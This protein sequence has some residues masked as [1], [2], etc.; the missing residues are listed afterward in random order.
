M[1]SSG[2]ESKAA[3]FPRHE[4][5]AIEKAVMESARGRWFLQEFARR[6]RSADT[7]TLLEAIGRLQ[8][9][10]AAA[11]PATAPVTEIASLAEVIK[12]TRADIAAIRND[13]LPGDGATADGPAIYASI[14]EHAKTTASEIMARTQR[15]QRLATELRAAN[16]N[17]AEVSILESDAQSFQTLAWSQDVLSQRIAKAMGLLSHVDDRISAMASP[18]EVEPRH[19]KFFAQDESLFEPPPPK[20]AARSESAAAPETPRL[21]TR[22]AT[23]I[24]HRVNRAASAA[25]AETQSEPSTAAP[26]TAPD[27]VEPDPQKPRIVIIRHPQGEPVDI[28]LAGELPEQVA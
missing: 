27:A 20:K 26:D 21:E 3:A 5:E 17:V 15:L 12:S 14:T 7:L 19:L 9:A 8:K 18:Q 16:A 23:V 4:Y 10:I 25:D 1:T 11:S 24:V 22:G 13:M 28:P 6:N 2:D